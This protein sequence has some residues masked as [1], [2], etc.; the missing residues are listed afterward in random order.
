M[1]PVSRGATD[2]PAQPPHAPRLLASRR[3][4]R[5]DGNG[6]R[7]VMVGLVMLMLMIVVV[8]FA[9]LNG[10]APPRPAENT[11]IGRPAVGAIKFLTDGDVCRQATIDNGTGQITDL[12]RLACDQSKDVRPGGRL[13][14]IRDS[15]MGR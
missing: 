12:G 2:L 8:G 4:A 5:R 6:R 1:K 11:Q 9:M 13:G 15:F 10:T 14:S 7:A 3:R